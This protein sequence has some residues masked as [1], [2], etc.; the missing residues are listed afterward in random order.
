MTDGLAEH[1]QRSNVMREPEAYFFSGATVERR[2]DESGRIRLPDGIVSQIR[3]YNYDYGYA[4]GEFK[5][6]FMTPTF[7]DFD[8][9][10]CY[11][12]SR[13]LSIDETRIS[14]DHYKNLM[15]IFYITSKGI[16]SS[17]GRLTLPRKLNGARKVVIKPDNQ[18]FVLEKIE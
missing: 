4:E 17:D 8:G 16:I 13:V 14:E 9:Y 12:P 6:V 1:L 18:V 3:K 15:D 7:S 5:A 11:S 2:V 10:W